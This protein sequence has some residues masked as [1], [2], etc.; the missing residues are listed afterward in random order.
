MALSI[1]EC[2]RGFFPV[3]LVFLLFSGPLFRGWARNLDSLEDIS[4]Y[5]LENS[6]EYQRALLDVL[7]ARNDLDGVVKLDETSFNFSSDY[8]GEDSAGLSARAGVNLPLIDQLALSATVSDD[9][10]GELGVTFS[11]LYHSTDRIKS[12]IKYDTALLYAEELAVE[13]QN[14]AL[15]AA[16]GWMSARRQADIQAQVVAVKEDV[17]NDEK[18]RYEAGEATLDELRDTLV[19]W[20]EART[21]LS[22]QQKNLR[23]AESALLQI[24]SAD[25]DTASI[26]MISYETLAAALDSLKGHIEPEGADSSGVYSVAAARKS[27]ESSEADLADTWIFDPDVNFTGTLN[28]PDVTGDSGDSPV[29]QAGVELTF[30]LEDFRKEDKRLSEKEVAQSRLEVTQAEMESR[31]TLQ[32]VLIAL[33]NAEQNRTLA[34]IEESQAQDLYEEYRYLMTLGDYSEA[35][36]ED[37]RLSWEQTKINSFSMLAEEYLAWRELLLY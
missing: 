9:Y 13:I 36:V 28:I 25:L 8:S 24:L 11:P 32:Q 10:S 37:A 35:E 7:S 20:T 30:S 12:D 23:S 17:Y 31:L 15:S 26:S 19:D 33:E 21:S 5:A 22:S 4:S 14:S 29:W 18:I 1:K 6:I 16:L 3:L 34:G 2:F 27:L